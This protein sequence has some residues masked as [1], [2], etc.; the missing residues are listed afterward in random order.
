MFWN[1]NE[2]KNVNISKL[3]LSKLPPLRRK[4]QEKF[5]NFRLRGVRLLQSCFSVYYMECKYVVLSRSLPPSLSLSLSAC[6]SVCL[7]VCLS[8][9]TAYCEGTR[10]RAPQTPTLESDVPVSIGVRPYAF[11]AR[12]W[13]PRF[14]PEALLIKR[15]RGM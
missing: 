14:T 12:V 6:L 1:L 10:H 3:Q 5:K 11:V 15:D 4:K 2:K 7:S 9:S 13:A 8:L